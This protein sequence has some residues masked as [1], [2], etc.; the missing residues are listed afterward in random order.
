MAES[1]SPT[2]KDSEFWRLV[3]KYRRGARSEMLQLMLDTARNSTELAEAIGIEA[4]TAGNY[5]REAKREGLVELV[6]PEADRYKM[7]LATERGR[8]VADEL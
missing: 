5:L 1:F 6:T 3:A 7:Y 2:E 4:N 8:A